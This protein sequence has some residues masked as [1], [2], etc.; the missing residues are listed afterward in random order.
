ME[1]YIAMAPAQERVPLS[2]INIIAEFYQEMEPAAT[3]VSAIEYA[4]SILSH[5]QLFL[6]DDIKN[7][8]G[9]ISFISKN[10]KTAHI[11]AMY[12]NPTQRSKGL[13]RKSLLNAVAQLKKHGFTSITL[14]VDAANFKAVALYR[15]VG[16]KVYAQGTEDGRDY[17][18]FR[19]YF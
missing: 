15:S 3:R 4:K 16:M 17:Q 13:A 1:H 12:I 7:P 8:I 18:L 10:N 2:I 5:S 14:G 11:N 6:I 9:F 19:F